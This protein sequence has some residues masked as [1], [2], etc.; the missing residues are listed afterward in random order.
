MSF[1]TLTAALTDSMLKMPS[2]TFENGTEYHHNRLP[3]Q[4]EV[5]D[6]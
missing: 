6:A 4:D 5:G 2:T 1:Q 3:F